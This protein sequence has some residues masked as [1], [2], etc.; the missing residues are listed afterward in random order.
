MRTALVIGATGLVGGH[1]T[2]Q[3]CSDGAWEKVI[4]LSRR[5]IIPSHPK[6]EVRVIDFDKPDATLVKADDIFCAIGTT[7]KKAGSKENQYRIDCEYPASLAAIAKN[8]GEFHPCFIYRRRSGIRQF[9][10]ENKG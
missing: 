6:M 8:N 2:E 3:L 7:L 10:P 9:L 1:L 5:K 4:V